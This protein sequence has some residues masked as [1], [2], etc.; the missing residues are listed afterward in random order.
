MT[1]RYDQQISQ[2]DNLDMLHLIDMLR[3]YVKSN[4]DKYMFVVILCMALNKVCSTDEW[5]TSFVEVNCSSSPLCV[6]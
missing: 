5:W 4:I 2:S 3:T 6:F 1:Q